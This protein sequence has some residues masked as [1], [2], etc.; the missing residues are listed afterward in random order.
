MNRVCAVI[1]TYNR[2]QMLTECISALKNQTSSCDVLVIDNAS[3]DGTFDFLRS[4][5]D[6]GFVSLDRNTGGAG[7]FNRGMRE[8]VERGYD[9]VWVMDDDVI[10]QPDALD[11]L[12]EADT[13]L[14]GQYG[15]L[16]SVPLWTD[17]TECRMNRPKL[18]KA[19]YTDIHLLKHSLVRAEQA[20][21]VSLFVKTT[22]IREYGLPIKEFFIW[23][24]DM[25]F[26][27]RLSVRGK[28]PCYLV[29][30]S[31]IIHAMKLN[32]GSSIALDGIERIDRYNYAFRNDNYL[33]RQE[34][35]KGICYYIGK[36]GLN[37]LRIIGKAE[38][39][40]LK[41]LWIIVK[42]MVAGCFFNPTIEFIDDIRR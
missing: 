32:V 39:H 40:K 28:L 27:R 13:L 29:G 6:V 19:F 37:I 14:K 7:G 22:V 26:T 23:G 33:Y 2:L 17:G 11:Y 18:Y 41:R 3:T 34:G 1:V 15:W 36:C 16:C 30:K 20:T 42:Q 24:D 35:F 5:E 25:E 4:I 21:F 8:A 9:Y 10:P 12:L 38:N 31:I